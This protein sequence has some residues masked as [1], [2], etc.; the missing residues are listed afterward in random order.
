[1]KGPKAHLLDLLGRFRSG[2]AVGDHPAV[3]GMITEGQ[4]G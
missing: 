1:M 3:L 2:F 4:V